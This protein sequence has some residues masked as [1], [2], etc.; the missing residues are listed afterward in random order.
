MEPEDSCSWTV[1]DDGVWNTECGQAFVLEDG[2]PKENFMKYCCYCGRGLIEIFPPDPYP[3]DE[4]VETA[5]QVAQRYGGS[6]L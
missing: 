3:E 6:E 5:Q 4:T 1:D 2:S